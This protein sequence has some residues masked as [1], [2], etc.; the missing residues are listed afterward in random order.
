[1]FFLCCGS[2]MR[3]IAV[4][5]RITTPAN[6][7]CDLSWLGMMTINWSVELAGPQ[8]GYSYQAPVGRIGESNE[9]C[10]HHPK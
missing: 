9:G 8:S 2:F 1:M 6:M 7:F 5:S 10:L 4:A 3:W